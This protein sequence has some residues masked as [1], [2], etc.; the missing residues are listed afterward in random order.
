MNKKEIPN[1]YLMNRKDIVAWYREE[2]I[3]YDDE[4]LY[5]IVKRLC[6]GYLPAGYNFDTYG[7]NSDGDLWVYSYYPEFEVQEL[8][9]NKIIIQNILEVLDDIELTEAILSSIFKSIRKD[10]ERKNDK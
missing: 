4:A 7:F 6:T 2:N 9:L 10:D 8:K 3:M 5:Q 1:L